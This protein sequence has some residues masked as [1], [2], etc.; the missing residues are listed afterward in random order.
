MCVVRV[1]VRV[2]VFVLVLVVWVSVQVYVSVQQ[3]QQRFWLEWPFCCP[4]LFLSFLLDLEQGI[5]ATSDRSQFWA[6]EKVF[7]LL[8]VCVLVFV[9]VFVCVAAFRVHSRRPLSPLFP[10]FVCRLVV[11]LCRD[12]SFFSCLLLLLFVQVCLSVLLFVFASLV[13]FERG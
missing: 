6:L 13:W 11:C 7:V 5:W 2:V 10:H 8:C 12:S 3:Q 1:I 4:C 9:W